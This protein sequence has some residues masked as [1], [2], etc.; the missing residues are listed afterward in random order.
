MLI[1]DFNKKSKKI[2]KI[3]NI[4]NK[5]TKLITSK[6]TEYINDNPDNMEIGRASCRERV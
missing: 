6:F 2:Q 5:N 4:E 3:L 1:K